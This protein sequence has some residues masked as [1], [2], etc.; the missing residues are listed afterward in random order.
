MY[1]S[2]NLRWTPALEP[3]VWHQRIDLV[4]GTRISNPALQ[5]KFEE[6]DLPGTKPSNQTTFKKATWI[7]PL[8][9]GREG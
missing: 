2:I 1:N 7:R 4:C 3:V 5:C 9:F 6:I 8:L